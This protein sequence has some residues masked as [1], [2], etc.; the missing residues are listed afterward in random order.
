MCSC[1]DTIA[2]EWGSHPKLKKIMGKLQQDP[3]ELLTAFLLWE[4]LSGHESRWTPY[5][6]LLPPL[7]S[8][9]DVV[10]PLFFSSDE[11]VEALQDERM[12]KT[13]RAERQRAKKAHGRFKRLFRSFPALK[14]LEWP[15]YAWARFL[16]NSRAFSIQGQRV[17]VPF[18]DIFNGKPDDDAREH[19]NGQRF[20]QLHD[21]QSMGMTIR[22]DRG[23]AKGSNSSKTTETTA[24]TCISCITASSWATDASTVRLFVFL[25][26]L[27]RT[28][29]MQTTRSE[30]KL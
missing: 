15:Q 8:R 11:V 6:S 14:A 29:K 20:L 27:T 23:A 21:L 7:S 28:S 13:A 10:S 25:H 24:T 9:D 2:R 26:S 17:L 22:A 5:L 1:H 3:E 18:G 12:V 4:E 16:V 30:R 19:D